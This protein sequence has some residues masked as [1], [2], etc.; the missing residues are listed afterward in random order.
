ML[1]ALEDPKITA[2]NERDIIHER[3]FNFAQICYQ[4]NEVGGE[5]MYRA[6]NEIKNVQKKKHLLGQYMLSKAAKESEAKFS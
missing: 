4:Q 3:L 1:Q 5:L 2:D 6:V